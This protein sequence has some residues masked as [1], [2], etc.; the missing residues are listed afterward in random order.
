MGIGMHAYA[1][2]GVSDTNST[3]TVHTDSLHITQQ[4]V[5][6]ICAFLAWETSTCRLRHPGAPPCS[7]MCVK[8]RAG[9]RENH[10]TPHVLSEA[11]VSAMCLLASP[12]AGHRCAHATQRPRRCCT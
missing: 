1:W 7:W 6:F 5:P 4:A 10:L 11:C 9:T 3:N 12:D 8:Q 2:E